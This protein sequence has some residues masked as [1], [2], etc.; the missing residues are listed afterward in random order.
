MSILIPFAS[1]SP[2]PWKNGGGSTI[3]IAIEPPG[4]NLHSFDWRLSLAT[5][6]HDGPFSHFPGV[7]RT[8]ALLD[9]AGMTLEIDGARQVLADRD[10]DAIAFAGEAAVNTILHDGATL[11]FNVMTRRAT[12]QHKLGR[13]HIDGSA[14]FAPGGQRC[15]L[16]L[17]AGENLT[18]SS[19]DERIGLV[20]YDAVVFEPGSLWQLEGVDATV[21]IID[22]YHRPASA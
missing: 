7:D 19:E 1:L 18:I 15:V 6:A 11:D 3:E 21:F 14:Q 2:T 4:A 20:R 5:I 9:G 10:A 8:L 12:C 17:A 16:F 22:F 13:R